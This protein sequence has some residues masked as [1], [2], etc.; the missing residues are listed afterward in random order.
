MA[1][2][3][4]LLNHKDLG[5]VQTMKSHPPFKTERQQIQEE[6]NEAEEDTVFDA[7]MKAAKKIH[8]QLD[9]DLQRIDDSLKQIKRAL[10]DFNSPGLSAAFADAIKKNWRGNNFDAKGA[11][12]HL[13]GYYKGR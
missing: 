3:A 7:D 10:S 4:D 6:L 13:S 8:R 11:V 9:T 2:L 12:K 5:K 1:K